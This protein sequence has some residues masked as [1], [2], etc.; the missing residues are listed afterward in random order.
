VMWDLVNVEAMSYEV[1]QQGIQWGWGSFPEFLASLGKRGLGVNLGAYV[2]LSPMR[3]YVMG[4]DTD[5]DQTPPETERMCELLREGLE[6]GAVGLSISFSGNHVG[7]EGRPVP[8]RLASR[9]ELTA[10]CSVM[11]TM[12]KGIIQI[13]SGGRSGTLPPP[14]MDRLVFLLESS[15]RPVMFTLAPDEPPRAME[16]LE[17][18]EPLYDRGL[19]PIPQTAAHVRLSQFTLTQPPSFFNRLSAFGQILNRTVAEQSATFND[20]AWRAQFQDELVNDPAPLNWAA[21]RVVQ[22]QDKSLQGK[23]LTDIAA[24][25][26]VDPTVAMLDVALAEGLET[27]FGRVRGEPDLAKVLPVVTHPR[28][29][30]GLSDA[31]AHVSQHCYADFT[32][33]F[34]QSYWRER[35][36]LALEDAVRL[37]TSDPAKS[38]CLADRGRLQVGQPA[39]VVVFDPQTVGSTRQYMVQDMP[40]GGERLVVDSTGIGAVVVNGTPAVLNGAIERTMSGELLH[41]A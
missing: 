20:S 33:S 13:A 28:T 1:L 19:E 29:V 41:A 11:K 16:T 21:V 6:A 22:S 5:R 39:D 34:L 2:P 30:V 31:G 9:A 10:L 24:D 12:G 23:S 35:K 26:G 3:R 18:I 38:V 37:L 8:S 25:R 4:T 15:G 17:Q 36:L 7:H 40:A 27:T 14:A 32:T